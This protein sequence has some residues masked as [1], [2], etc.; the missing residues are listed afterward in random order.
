MEGQGAEV[1]TCFRADPILGSAR[2]IFIFFSF[3]LDK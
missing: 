2:F 3:P 1:S